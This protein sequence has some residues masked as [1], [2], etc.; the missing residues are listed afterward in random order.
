MNLFRWFTSKLNPKGQLE[1]DPATLPHWARVAFAAL[2]ARRVQALYVETY[3]DVPARFLDAVENAIT[4]AEESAA[5]ALAAANSS[6]VV[7]RTLQVGTETEV[8]RL[9]LSVAAS[10]AQS[11]ASGPVGSG[12]WS[13]NA[14]RDSEQLAETM[15][16]P[17]L[18]DR[19]ASDYQRF[20]Q[21]QRD[22]AWTDDSPVAGRTIVPLS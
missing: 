20:V 14:Y 8:D 9:V 10:A 2:C 6:E 12:A 16:N 15:P 13:W 17:W 1:V 21:A 7:K 5:N 19:L 22:F 4:L 3:S 18:K 11:V